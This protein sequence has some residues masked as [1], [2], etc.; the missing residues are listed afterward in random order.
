MAPALFYL[1]AQIG[2]VGGSIGL[3]L[4]H[5]VLAVPYVVVTMTAV[6]KSHD[7]RLEQAAGTIGER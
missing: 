5:V 7:E 4:S 6:L 2:L 3:I 1:H